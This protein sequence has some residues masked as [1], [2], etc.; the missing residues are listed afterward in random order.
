M[1]WDGVERRRNERR[2]PAERRLEDRR[3]SEL[4]EE[5]KGLRETLQQVYLSKSEVKREFVPREEHRARRIALFFICL[6]VVIFSMQ[7][8]DLHRDYCHYGSALTA[9]HGTDR[10]PQSTAMV[11]MCDIAFPTHHHSSPTVPNA[12]D[13]DVVGWF[14]YGAVVV[15]AAYWIRHG[16]EEEKANESD[17]LAEAPR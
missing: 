12:P 7:I 3:V 4:A 11:A 8:T 16:I 13:Y 17:G 14:L 2:T 6:L 10:G 15:L 9:N 1:T 5:V